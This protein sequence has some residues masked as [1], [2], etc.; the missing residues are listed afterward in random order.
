MFVAAELVR[1]LETLAASPSRASG[2]AS[3]IREGMKV[4][5]RYR[6]KTRYYPGVVRRENR[7]GTFDIDY[8]D[9]SELVD[10]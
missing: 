3:M 6:G 2:G 4:E 1:P 9:V 5:A 8:D 7:D 10:S